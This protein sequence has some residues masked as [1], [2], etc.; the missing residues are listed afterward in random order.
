MPQFWSVSYLWVDRS[1]Y[2]HA[3]VRVPV[4]FAAVFYPECLRQRVFIRLL[5]SVVNGTSKLGLLLKAALVVPMKSLALSCLFLGNRV[6][7]LKEE[8]RV[9]F[10]VLHPTCEGR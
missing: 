9:S 7:T 5:V 2:K 10:H 8:L 4:H 3:R 1:A 6:G